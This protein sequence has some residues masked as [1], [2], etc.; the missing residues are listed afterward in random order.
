MSLLF[1][2]LILFRTLSEASIDIEAFSF[3]SHFSFTGN[4]KE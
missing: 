4:K 1:R 2:F 3:F